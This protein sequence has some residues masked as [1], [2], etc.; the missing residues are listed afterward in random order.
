[1]EV[2]QLHSPRAE[3]I[4]L[5]AALPDMGSVGGLVA[6]F[7]INHL[8]IKPFVEIT[9][10]DK[11]FVL[12]KDGLVAEIPSVFRLYYSDRA[13]LVVMTGNS[14]PNDTRELYELCE[15]SLDLAAA[16]GRLERVYTCGG[17]H[18]EEIA[19]E[20]RV[21]GV[22]NNPVLFRE[23]D[24]LGIREIGAEVSSITWFN[25]VILGVAK[26]RKIDALGLYGELIDPAIP[27]PD[28]ARAVLRALTTLLSLPQI[29]KR[30][31]RE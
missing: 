15:R 17:Y 13:S 27:Q 23:L 4:N 20:P 24:K 11:P 22:S 19:G 14:Q 5:V 16:V 29:E 9:S 2:R 18:R 31:R 21:Y 10:Y 25:G 30:E 3:K 8:A 1:L 28:A 26:R 6:E 12:C 7:L